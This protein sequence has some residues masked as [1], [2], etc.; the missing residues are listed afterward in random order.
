MNLQAFIVSV[1]KSRVTE[2]RCNTNSF[3]RSCQSLYKH[4]SNID[5]INGHEIKTSYR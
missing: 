3:R 4:V 2:I 1:Y 5:D